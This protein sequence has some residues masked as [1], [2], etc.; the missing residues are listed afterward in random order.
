MENPDLKYQSLLSD[1]TNGFY[2][3]AGKEIRQYLS[4]LTKAEMR[5]PS[6][7]WF[8]AELPEFKYLDLEFLMKADRLFTKAEKSVQNDVVLSRRV[9]HARLPVDRSILYLWPGLV[10]EWVLNGKTA[11]EFPLNH[12]EYVSRYRKTMQEQI[13][14]R[15]SPEGNGLDKNAVQNLVNAATTAFEK[16]QYIP[17]PFP[18]EFANLPKDT[19]FQYPAG[20]INFHFQAPAKLVKDPDA[21]TGWAVKVEQVPISDKVSSTNDTWDPN[22]GYRVET[23]IPAGIDK[24]KPFDFPMNWGLKN[25]FSGDQMPNGKPIIAENI[26]ASGYHWYKMG[27]FNI[28]GNSNVYFFWTR[29]VRVFF[30]QSGMHEVWAR[31]KFDGPAF[32]HGNPSVINS[33]SIDQVVLVKK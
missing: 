13:D 21:S 20:S 9:R 33:I 22:I 27:S 26:T 14:L 1:F 3:P 11:D 23:G 2:G 10:Q 6:H 32:P 30:R 16:N 31:I 24:T 15:C 19:V 5:K 12:D 17:M 25:K 28:G 18:Q 7:I 29:M 8:F 4:E